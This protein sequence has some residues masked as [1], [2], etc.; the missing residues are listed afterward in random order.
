MAKENKILE[1][2]K[3]LKKVTIY[4][5]YERVTGGYDF[6]GDTNFDSVGW[7]E[8]P[9]EGFIELE[10]DG[11]VMYVELPE[12]DSN[13]SKSE[14]KK[15]TTDFIKDIKEIKQVKSVKLG[16]FD[17]EKDEYPYFVLKIN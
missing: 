5:S 1:F 9:F 2:L 11:F 3:E 4:L 10:N 15:I 8:A 7:A 14:F 12:V 16:E 6:I 13:L 17:N